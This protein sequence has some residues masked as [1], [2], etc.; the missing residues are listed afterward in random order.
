MR[1]K[2]LIIDGFLMFRSMHCV[3][4][5]AGSGFLSNTSNIT[6]L[7]GI[8]HKEKPGMVYYETLHSFL[9]PQVSLYGTL[10]L[11]FPQLHAKSS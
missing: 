4:N 6:N 11:P 2:F 3:I 8:Y 10:Y 9:I 1:D 7:G 5:L